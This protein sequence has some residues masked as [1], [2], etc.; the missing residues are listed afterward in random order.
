VAGNI[1]IESAAGD[2]RH[3]DLGG[4]DAL[5]VEQR[6]GQVLAER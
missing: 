6:P 3:I 5:F 4:E 2:S 1:E